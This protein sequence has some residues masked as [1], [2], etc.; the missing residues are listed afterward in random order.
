M[1]G[2]GSSGGDVKK[3]NGTAVA[4]P[5]VAGVP[6]TDTTHWNGTAV[7]TP[8]TAGSPKVTLTAG[9]GIGQILLTSGAVTV[10]TNN[11]K[12]G[13]SLTAGSY[14]VRASSTQT[15][16]ITMASVTT[17]TAT[18]S[19]VT[20]TRATVSHNGLRTAVDT[21]QQS[22]ST[23]ILTNATTVTVTREEQVSTTTV[24]GYTVSELV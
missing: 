2:V 7:T 10:G 4:T 18:I 24:N 19:S 1:S 9:S 14:S 15:G 6:E 12:T 11:D 23:M 13:Y 5:T 22:F 21:N 3:W 17:N 20:T 16:T 8:D